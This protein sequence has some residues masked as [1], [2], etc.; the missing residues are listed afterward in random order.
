MNESMDMREIRMRRKI[1]DEH[2]FDQAWLS[3]EAHVNLADKYHKFV[4][5]CFCCIV[6]LDL[7]LIN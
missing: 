5:I 1:S 4:N 6:T 3:G 7:Q 2:W